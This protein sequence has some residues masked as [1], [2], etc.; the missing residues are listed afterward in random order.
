MFLQNTGEESLELTGLFFYKGKKEQ[1]RDG[2]AADGEQNQLGESLWDRR[3]LVEM[4]TSRLM[5]ASRCLGCL[6]F[7]TS[8]ASSK[9]S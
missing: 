1:H 3:R 5:M 8:K 7:L 2:L 4:P 6:Y 9:G